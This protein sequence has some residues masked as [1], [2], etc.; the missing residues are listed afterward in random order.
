MQ[1]DESQKCYAKLKK[2]YTKSTHII[3]NSIYISFWE[4]QNIR[5]KNHLSDGK[6][7]RDGVWEMTAKRYKGTFF[8]D[9]MSYNMTVMVIIQPYTFVKLIEFYTLE[10]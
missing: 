6:G 4:R 9:E 5:D 8:G 1:Q 2:S 3:D 10:R 7:L